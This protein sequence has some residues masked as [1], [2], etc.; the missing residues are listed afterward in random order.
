MDEG[1]DRHDA[2]HAIASILMSVM[3]ADVHRRDDDGDLTTEY[4]RKLTILTAVGW[5]SQFK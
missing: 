1:L 4:N 2:V 3:S 5:R